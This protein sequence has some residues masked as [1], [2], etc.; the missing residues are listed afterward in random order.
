[1]RKISLIL[2]LFALSFAAKGQ[3]ITRFE[4]FFDTDPGYGLGTIT[5]ITPT[6]LVTDFNIPISTSLLAPGF[7]KLYMR[8]QNAANQWTHTHIR[9]FY[10]MNVGVAENIVKFE[11]FFDTDPG[12]DNGT[13][14]PVA[15]PSPTVSN[16]DIFA[17]V[18]ALSIGAHTIYVRAKDS[19]GEWTQVVTGSFS[20]TAAAPPT[21]LSFSPTSGLVGTAVTITG[22]NF[23][24]TPVNNMVAFNGTTA[25]VTSS[26]ATT[27]ITNVPAGATTG[28]ITVTVAGNTATSSTNFTVTVCPA[29]PTVT[30]NQGC[31]NTTVA[32]TA[33]GG[34]NGQYRWYSVATG[35]TAITGEVN[36]T[37]TTPS[38]PATT[39]YYVSINNGC[40]SVRTSVTA[41]L[42]AL[43][44]P[45]TATGVSICASVAATLTASGGTN[46]QYKWYT[47]ATGGTAIA[48]A[49]NSSYTTPLLS[50]TTNYF[51]SVTA[52]GCESARTQATATITI[53]GCAPV[54]ATAPL[55]TQVEGKIELNLLSLITTVGTLDV[56]S[57]KIVVQPSSGAVATIVSGVLTIDYKGKPFSGRESITI[58]ACNTTGTCSQQVFNIE[59]AGDVIVYNAMSANGDDKNAFLYLQYIE[60]LAATRSNQVA[61]YNRWG[62]EV[63]SI[64]DY[65]NKTRVF[66]GLTNDGSKL[67][68]GTYFYRVILPNTGRTMM[69][70]ISLKY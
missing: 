21:I 49:T 66:A 10:V 47:V 55:A 13:S 45:P 36:G 37:Y 22:T 18:S 68:A 50:A 19:G 23:S 16:Q 48:G 7:H 15:L 6:T 39:T 12:F 46:G 29:S 24:A 62:D 52:G 27:I 17:D 58:E 53:A 5:N 35:G 63:F 38:L 42:L 43:P 9:D 20:V 33:S 25:V 31:Q 61:I 60:V 30:P 59:V 4:H 41:T 26:T 8:A 56:S 69:G 3:N 67:P 57:I 1:M 28:P 14:A 54:I 51:V 65:D 70:F 34:T 40:E 44:A 11:Y 2:F 32:L 64:S